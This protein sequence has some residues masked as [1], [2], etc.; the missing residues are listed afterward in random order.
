M[1]PNDVIVSIELPSTNNPDWIHSFLDEVNHR[2]PAA[3]NAHVLIDWRSN[4]R[5]LTVAKGKPRP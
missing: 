3:A 5:I 2:L 1:D 4:R